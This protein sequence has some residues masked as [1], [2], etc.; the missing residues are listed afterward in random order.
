MVFRPSEIG[1]DKPEVR[2]FF[3]DG[4]LVV[5]DESKLSRDFYLE[6][7][8]DGRA[9]YSLGQDLA[10]VPGH[11]AEGLSFLPTALRL[12][13]TA[14]RKHFPHQQ[15]V[16]RPDVEWGRSMVGSWG[17]EGIG[18]VTIVMVIILGLVMFARFKLT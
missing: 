15:W 13:V 10:E 12:F 9:I 5:Q 4:R 1:S 6:I 8:T 14:R 2:V 3:D 7:K 11:Q 17:W 18:F 16:F